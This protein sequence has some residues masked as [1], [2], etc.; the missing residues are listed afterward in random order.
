MCTYQIFDVGAKI[1][2]ELK[3]ELY[4]CL[5]Y[6]SIHLTYSNVLLQIP[7]THLSSSLQSHPNVDQWPRD[8]SSK[9]HPCPGPKDTPE[10]NETRLSSKS[11]KKNKLASL[12]I[13]VLLKI[14]SNT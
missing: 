13:L 12:N 8:G 10:E 1:S 9:S 2:A 6:L 3:Y 11:E 14:L 7:P 5:R 4:I